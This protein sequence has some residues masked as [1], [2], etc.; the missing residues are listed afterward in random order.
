MG[1]STN[2]TSRIGTNITWPKSSLDT[3]DY[4]AGV[5]VYAWWSTPP[6]PQWC[7]GNILNATDLYTGRTL[8]SQNYNNTASE[9]IQGAGFVVVE[10]GKVAFGGHGMQ[11][12]CW[13][14]RTGQ[15]LWDSELTE[16]PW[17]AWW[18]YST[19]TYD[20]NETTTYII[21]STYEGV[22]AIDLDTGKIAWHYQ[23]ANVV[24][25]EDPY[26]AT[27]FFTAVES[28][29][30]K[31]FA[32]NGEHTPSYPFARDWKIHCINATTGE[33][34]WK[35]LNPMVPGAVAD[36]YL[37]ASNPYDGYM[38]VFGRGL[39]KTAVTASPKTIAQGAQILIEGTIMDQ[40]PGQPGTPCVA[41]NSMETQMEYIHLGMPIDGIWHNETI[42]GVP[43]ALTAI[44]SDGAVT[45]LG[46]VTTNGYY[47]TF[48]FAWTPPKQDTYTILA[49][50]AADDSYGSSSAATAVAVGPEP[51]HA[52]TQ[53]PSETQADVMPTLTGILVA[54]IIA[55]ILS[56][57]AL[58]VV[59]R[60]H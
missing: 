54:V 47:G 56:A 18:P 60:K 14:S 38:Y 15:K 10:R 52:P 13:N 49:S 11:W 48:S 40:S 19:A 27:P 1:T 51:T 12:A 37:T 5:S 41:K 46:T 30:G 20:V 26:N 2:F 53:S 17:G 28:A 4:E 16:Y 31:I 24:P 9:N 42:T 35:M 36:G 25:F 44:G 8:W 22:Y 29:D 39:S 59:L 50:F 33:G 55:I 3:I 23:D 34:I 21:T 7:I 6:G 58:V 45:D 57:I 43:V 32:Y